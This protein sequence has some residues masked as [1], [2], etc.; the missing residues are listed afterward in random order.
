MLNLKR[1]DRAEGRAPLSLVE[2]PADPQALMIALAEIAQRL[3][4]EAV[5]LRHL[6][7]HGRDLIEVN[8]RA[9]VHA[10]EI[11]IAAAGVLE[12]IE[13]LSKALRREGEYS[14]PYGGVDDGR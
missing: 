9:K 6:Y 13:A 11:H 1:E 7:D 3:G 2:A 4:S 14:M 10:S 5:V 8:R 12:T